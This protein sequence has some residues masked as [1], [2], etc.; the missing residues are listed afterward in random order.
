M[1]KTAWF[2]LTGPLWS[3]LIHTQ[4]A[5]GSRAP[6]ELP[7]GAVAGNLITFDSTQPFRRHLMTHT[8]IDDTYENIHSYTSYLARPRGLEA[9]GDQTH[10]VG[11][12]KGH[13]EGGEVRRWRW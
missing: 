7:G 6:R 2:E 9:Y 13:M 11:P 1:Q 8:S 4:G 3:I 10:N 5:G 12:H